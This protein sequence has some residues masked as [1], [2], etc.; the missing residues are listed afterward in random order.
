MRT[1]FVIAAVLLLV[2]GLAHGSQGVG[3]GVMAGEPTGICLNLWTGSDRAIDV[4]AGWSI[5]ED[6]WLY[7]HC[8][9]LFHGHE[10]PGESAERSVPYYFGI[11]SR[12]LLRE[13][14]DTRIGLRIPFGVNYVF[15]DGRFDVFLELAPMMDLLPETEFDFGGGVGLRYYF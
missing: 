13:S 6:G 2:P 4:A 12:V 3:L 8:D 14:E 10:F 7:L 5:G 1:L 11:G 9:Y 15:E